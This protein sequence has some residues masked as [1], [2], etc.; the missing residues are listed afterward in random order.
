ML[1]RVA[2]SLFWLGRYAERA[3]NYSRFIDVNFN[4]SIDL[5]PGLKE[6]WDPLIAATG[7][8]AHFL[9]LYGDNP[10]R[11]NAINF[12][13]FD[14]RNPNSII[15]TVKMARENA[16]I[17]R[18][19]IPNDTW[20]VLND[21]HHFV[22]NAYKRKI[23]KKED[24]K[25]CFKR[26]KNKLQLLNG[27]ANDTI[28]RTQ[29]WY[30]TKTGQYL[31]RADKTS[32]ILDVKYHFLLPSVDDVGSPLDFLHWNALLKSVSGF[33]AYR[34][35][36]GRINPTA[37]VEYLVL[38]RYFPRSILFCLMGAENCLHEI[39]GE[40]RGYSNPAEKAIGNLRSDLE[41]ADVNDVFQSGLHEFLDRMQ[42]RINKISEEVHTQYFRIR[43]N[44]TPELQNQTQS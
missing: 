13:G 34:R 14:S 35:I 23:W 12:L 7:D 39:S 36:Y 31:E 10:S 42:I 33:N 21:L 18:E 19:N 26:I 38:N 40:Q 17:V 37:I 29:G 4:L 30:F 27:I 6:Q 9:E 20:E 15:S 16:R 28:P 43:S 5:P 2:N 3:E 8:K 25:D 44:F 22:Q 32:R 1:S 41:F 24:P 11:E